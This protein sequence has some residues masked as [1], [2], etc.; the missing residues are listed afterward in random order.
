MFLVLPFPS[1][2]GHDDRER[3]SAELRDRIENEELT[4]SGAN[5]K[6]ESVPGCRRVLETSANVW[7]RSIEKSTWVKNC[8]FVQNCP[9]STIETRENVV[10]KKFTAHI[11]CR[12]E[13]FFFQNALHI[14]KAQRKSVIC[15]C[16]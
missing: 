14:E 15:L 10:E 3:H 7:K 13:Y 4:N 9:C 2:N 1:P 6:H 8:T 5:G 16:T 12:G 11:I